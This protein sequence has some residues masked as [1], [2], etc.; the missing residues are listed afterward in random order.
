MFFGFR[1]I[2]AFLIAVL[3]RSADVSVATPNVLFIIADDLS[4]TLSCYGAEGVMTP[5]LDKL[6]SRGRMFG[7]AYCQA[8]LCN[9]S[10]TSILTGRRPHQT[11][12][13]TNA[14]HFRGIYPRIT[15]LP[16]HFKANGYHTVG[17]GKIF[18]NWGQSLQGDPQSWSEPETNHWAAHYHDWYLPG[19]PYQMHF[20]IKKG[21]AV[22]CEDVPDEAY[23]DGRTANAAV[24]KLRELK[25]T[26]FFLAVGFWKP[27]LPYN[28][29]K[30]YW[31]LYDRDALPPV[32]YPGP[33]EEVPEI[34]YVNSKEARSYTDV[35][36]EGPISPEKKLELRHGYLAAISYLDAQVGKILDELERLGLAENTIVVFLSDHGYHAGEHGQFG[37]WTNFEIGTRVPLIIAAPGMAEPGVPTNSIA[38]LVD[39]YP[40]LL[41]LANMEPPG[42]RKKRA[43]VSLAPIIEDP[44]AE[45]K[46]YAVSQITRP[47]GAGPDYEV[48][49]STV[50]DSQLRYNVWMDRK[51]GKVLAE[52]LYDLSIDLLNA[53]NRIDDA[54]YAKQ[55]K[56]LQGALNGLLHQ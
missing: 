44:D 22:Q 36:K 34:A 40:T 23:I 38:E 52:E 42:D 10:R 25:E 41:D 11:R 47:L 7:R 2:L 8:S 32:R 4:N 21:P 3:L 33:V 37:K 9:P 56:Q 27:H 51:S 14:P 26:P 53:E 35:P 17:I 1:F 29:P 54:E 16:Q 31:D 49:G 19:R 30:K 13:W 46:T 28:A 50:R 43:G 20:D 6:A 39:L 12:I 55:R 5:H 18:H 24:N 48:V 45:V 15:T